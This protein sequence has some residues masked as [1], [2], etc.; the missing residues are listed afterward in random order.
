M[1]GRAIPGRFVLGVAMALSILTCGQASAQEL[2]FFRVATGSTAGTY[3]PIGGLIADAISAPPGAR[4]CAGGGSCGV[5][6][7]V[8]VAVESTGSVANV[9]AI[10]SGR[11]ESGFV[12]G[13]IAAWAY[14]GTGIRQGLP[15]A[16]R[17]RAIASLYAESIHLVASSQSGIASISDLRGKRVSL[18]EPGSGSQVSARIILGAAGL[19]EADIRPEYLPARQAASRMEQGTVDAFFFVGG[20]PASMIAE[21]ASRYPVTIVPI[22]AEAGDRARRQGGFFAADV[23]PAETYAGVDTDIPT[24]SVGA[25]WI[26]SADQPE[27]LIHA[28]TAALWNDDTRRRLDDGHAKGRMIRPETALTGLGLPL[29]PGAERY[30]REIGLLD[31]RP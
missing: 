23:I 27:A 10:E 19:T 25:Q 31:Q 2:R 29:H 17:L 6:G 7:L 16:A 26:T 13:D 11:V 30:Y 28:V 14:A 15:P 24:L 8:A 1:G 12:Q 3:Y 20:Y 22:A 18:D 4:P 21:L 9:D 5:P